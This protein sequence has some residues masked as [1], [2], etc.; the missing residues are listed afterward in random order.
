MFCF[1]FIKA[2]RTVA[3]FRPRSK[4]YRVSDD[5]LGFNFFHERLAPSNVVCLFVFFRNVN[6][7]RHHKS[8]MWKPIFGGP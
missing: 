7:S 2:D 6:R 4:V 5:V 3:K 8:G 1:C